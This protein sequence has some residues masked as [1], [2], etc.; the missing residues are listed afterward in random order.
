[1]KSHKSYDW[2]G[3]RCGCPFRKEGRMKY[4]AFT[5]NDTDP[6]FIGVGKTSGSSVEFSNSLV[7]SVG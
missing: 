3:E 6:G 4:S 7:S 2:D 5:Q 1:M